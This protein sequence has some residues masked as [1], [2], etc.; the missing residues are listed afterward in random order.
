M[1]VSK[2]TAM[3]LRSVQ[4]QAVLVKSYLLSDSLILYTSVLSGVF[5]SKMASSTYGLY[6][7]FF[8]LFGLDK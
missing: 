5:L 3:K 2:K 8:I 4:N 6:F 7:M 1:A